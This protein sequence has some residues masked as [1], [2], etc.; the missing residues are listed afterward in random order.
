MS[1][2]MVRQTGATIASMS[3]V[4][5]DTRS[6]MSKTS[7]WRGQDGAHIMLSF[8]VELTESAAAGVLD[9]SRHPA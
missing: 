2:Q 1:V 5:E 8:G 4:S 3:Q 6:W 7:S 9:S